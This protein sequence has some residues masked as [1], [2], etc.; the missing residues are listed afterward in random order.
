METNPTA[1]LLGLAS[2]AEDLT[3][4]EALQ[5]LLAAGHQAWCEGVDDVRSTVK[6]EAT[7][8]SD[9][10]VADW[11][12]AAG[13]LWELGMSREEAVSALAFTVWEDAP[14]ALAYT[15]LAERAALFGACL[16]PE[17]PR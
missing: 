8:L 16:L 17:D 6:Q 4:R 2:R 10:E 9:Q 1:L 12:A 15:S 14:A 3:D 13:A 5:E 7:G 11:C